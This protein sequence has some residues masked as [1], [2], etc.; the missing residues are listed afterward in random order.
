MTRKKVVVIGG[1][2]GQSAILRGIKKIEEIDITA[3]VTVAD[4]GGSTGRLRRHFHIPAM[5][6]IRNVL[7]SLG[8]S[9]TLLATLMDY[10][11]ESSGDIDEDVMGHNLGNLI[12]TAMTQS[13]GSFMESITTLCKVL[14]V[15]G[16]IIPATSQVITLFARMQDGTIVRGES[17]IPNISNRIR[18]VF[19]EEKVSATPA[20]IEAILNADVVVLGIGSVYTSILPNLI[21]PEIKEALEKSKAKVVYYCNAMTQ[22]GETDGYSLEDHVEAFRHHGSDVDMVVMADDEIPDEILQRYHDEGSVEV[23][24]KENDHD[25]EIMRCSLLDFSRSLVRHDSDKIRESLELILERM[26]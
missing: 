2:H 4:D 15:R 16:D 13:C 26:N 10:R 17:N 5:G 25:Y 14:N 24:M 7:I 3:I 19:Y 9:E 21:I 11:F 8:E 1:G 12:L 18:E 23:K 22:P 20:A 6:D